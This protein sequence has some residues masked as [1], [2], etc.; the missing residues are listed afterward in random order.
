MHLRRIAKRSR[1]LHAAYK[2]AADPT[3]SAGSA[4]N[5]PRD[6]VQ[7]M[8]VLPNTMVPVAGLLQTLDCVRSVNADGIEGDLAECGVYGGGCSG[9]MALGNRSS[10]RVRKVLL[11]DSFVGMPAPTEKDVEVVPNF[12]ADKGGKINLGELTAIGACVGP[13]RQEV[14]TFLLDRLKL[15]PSEYSIYEGWFQTTLQAAQENIEKLAIL[16]LDGDWYE[17]TMVCLRGLYSKLASGGY[18]I[19]DDY[20]DFSGCR[21]AV[22]EFFASIGEQPVLTPVPGTDIHFF[23]K[24]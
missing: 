23:R 6:L 15:E 8:K 11:F 2:Y 16:R 10:G 5:R 18:L 1:L 22:S 14:E 20:G 21:Q 7:V 17:S 12:I 9:L 3:A 19:I 4:F 13:S 24:A